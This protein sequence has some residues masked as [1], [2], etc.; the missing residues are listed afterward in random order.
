MKC[1]DC[2]ITMNKMISQIFYRKSIGCKCSDGNSY[3][4]KY[5]LNV[6][7]QLGVRFET[8]VKYSW[9]NYINP[10]SGRVSQASI[11]FVIFYNNR[12]IPLETDGKFHR[13][14]NRMNGQTKEMSKYIDKQ[15]DENCLKY[16]GEET[17]RISDEGDIKENILNS[18]LAK[19]F[20]LSNINWDK[21]EEFALKNLAKEVCKYWSNKKEWETTRDLAKIFGVDRS[22]IILYLKRGSKLE[23]CCY[24][25]KEERKKNGSRNG[26]N[27]NTKFIGTPLVAIRGSNVI[28]FNS[29][30]ELI[31]KSQDIF[32]VKL[33]SKKI[34]KIINNNDFIGKFKLLKYVE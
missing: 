19:E 27:S 23:W 31:K 1:P 16:L 24:D 20:D 6:L 9:N 8:E 28:K 18:K 5:T 14:D 30:T 2:G 17:I 21:C 26:K 29:Y 12:E 11:D 10:K 4:S 15:R 7:S 22:T 25:S 33:T 3:I 34:N 13:E 32:D